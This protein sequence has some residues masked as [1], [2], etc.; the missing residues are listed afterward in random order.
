MRDEVRIDIAAAAI[1]GNA[2]TLQRGPQEIQIQRGLRLVMS[3]SQ[4]LMLPPFD[5]RAYLAGQLELTDAEVNE[6]LRRAYLQRRAG[7]MPRQRGAR[8]SWDKIATRCNEFDC[9]R[10][11]CTEFVCCVCCTYIVLGSL[12]LVW[13]VC[14]GNC[15]DKAKDTHLVTGRN[16]S[17]NDSI[18]E[19]D[20]GMTGE[21]IV[22]TYVIP[23]IWIFGIVVLCA[24]A[25]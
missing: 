23:A 22:A 3:H 8:F 20:D 14:E 10:P 18:M 21:S 2:Q 13:L 17:D 4:S 1:D 19:T 7:V 5:V 11:R 25:D 12:L 9:P 24:L 16:A 6:V 15:G